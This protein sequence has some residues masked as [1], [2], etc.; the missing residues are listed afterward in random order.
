MK[1][2][3]CA[4]SKCSI[5]IVRWPPPPAGLVR[6]Q[7]DVTNVVVALR[8]VGDEGELEPGG[9]VEEPLLHAVLVLLFLI[10]VQLHWRHVA[11]S[12]I[13]R[14]T[15]TCRACM[16]FHAFAVLVFWFST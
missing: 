9:R 16:Q 14:Q 15:W 12:R 11:W 13:G 1:V 4:T 7:G 6:T 3:T 10:V 5:D 2:P 8:L